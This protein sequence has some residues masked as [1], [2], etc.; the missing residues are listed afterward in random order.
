MF[1]C[2]IRTVGLRDTGV[3]LVQAPKGP[4]VQFERVFYMPTVP[5]SRG[6]KLRSREG[7]CPRYL[8]MVESLKCSVYVLLRGV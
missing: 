6:Y 2:L 7:A 4:Y 8:S 5:Y 3:T 1:V